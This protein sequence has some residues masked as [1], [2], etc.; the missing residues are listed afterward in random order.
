MDREAAGRLLEAELGHYRSKPYEDLRA[1][2]G[3]HAAYE[4]PNPDGHPYQVEVQVVWDARP[5]GAIRVLAGIDDGGW[6]A[7]RPV[8][9]DL[10]IPAP[11]EDPDA[12]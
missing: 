8:A 10:L 12:V 3:S 11:H 7:F 9:R 2:V 4:L 5:G 1:L 6:S